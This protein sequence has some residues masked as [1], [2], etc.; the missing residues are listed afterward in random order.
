MGNKKS[1]ND[2]FD[3][4]FNM[5]LAS[6]QLTKEAQKSRKQEG[7]EKQ[8]VK[9]SIEQGI[10]EN[11]QIHAEN[12]IRKKNESLNYLKLASKMDAVAS[13]IE[14]AY[15][16]QQVTGQMQT[17]VKQMQK[18][19]NLMNF[20]KMEESMREFETMFENL[21]VQSQYVNQTLAS[22]TAS[23]TPQSEVNSLISQVADEHQLQVTTDMSAAGEGKLQAGQKEE[24]KDD[25][26]MN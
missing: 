2:L 14:T 15:R 10:M 17:S 24:N 9:K 7:V 13:R 4:I 16:T 25:D 19:M 22:S 5:K 1:K 23:S 12:A 18:A 11:A 6:K 20:D 21:D 8:K 26:I 3:T